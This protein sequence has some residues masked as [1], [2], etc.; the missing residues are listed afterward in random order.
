MSFTTFNNSF[1]RVIGY[2]WDPE[3]KNTDTMNSIWL[4]G[5]EYPSAL[6]APTTPVEDDLSEAQQTWPRAFLDDFNSRIW[7]TYRHDFPPIPRSNS[8]AGMSIMTAVRAQ[9]PVHAQG[10]TSDQGWGCM[11]RSGQCVLANALAILQFGRS[12][13][14]GQHPEEEKALLAL[15]ADDPEAPFSIHKFVHQG[16]LR[17]IRSGSWFGPTPTAQCIKALADAHSTPLAVYVTLDG[18]L[19]S[20]TFHRHSSSRSNHPT[21]PQ[22]FTPVLLLIVT[23]LGLD[24]TNPLYHE[25][26]KA[27][28]EMP[29]SIGIAG[30]RPSSSH[31]FIGVQGDYLFYLD[32]HVVRPAVTFKNPTSPSRPS[33][34][35]SPQS[36]GSSVSSGPTS[37]GPGAASGGI[38]NE[39]WESFHTSRLRRLHVKDVD[40]SMMFAFLIKSE[41]EWR[42]FRQGVK[43]VQGRSVVH[44]G[45]NEPVSSVRDSAVEEVVSEDD[46]DM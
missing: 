3:P 14:K 42:E 43:E 5:Q 33:S 44:V 35:S 46:E 17:D 34:S 21:S 41:E 13:R 1:Q 7:M 36:P 26:L 24:S 32:P 22:E 19:Y 45:E 2:L 6:P 15:F 10:F 12:W 9:L 11:I 25:A 30:G 20:D 29:H 18:N 16:E 4:L 37:P 28:L 38:S 40:P 39:D 31:Y 23:R 8:T 27:T